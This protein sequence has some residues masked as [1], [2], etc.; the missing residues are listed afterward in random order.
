MKKF[1]Q[2]ASGVFLALTVPVFAVMGFHVLA[3]QDIGSSGA[4]YHDAKVASADHQSGGCCCP[5]CTQAK[6]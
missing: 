4:P 3:K 2:P 1:I 6:Q 5:Y